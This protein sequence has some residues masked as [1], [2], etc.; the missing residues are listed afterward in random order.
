MHKLLAILVLSGLC[1]CT[2]PINPDEYKDAISGNALGAQ[3][4]YTVPLAYN[5]VVANLKSAAGRC[6]QYTTNGILTNHGWVALP[7]RVTGEVRV[8]KPGQAQLTVQSSGGT[9]LFDGSQK[10]K[11][12]WYPVH[13][14]RPGF[15]TRQDELKIWAVRQPVEPGED[16]GKRQ[17]SVSAPSCEA[18]PP[19][20]WAL[21]RLKCT[22]ADAARVSKPWP[23][24]SRGFGA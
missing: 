22:R 5:A 18:A 3:E 21:T 8:V 19:A 1:A 24:S 20:G 15:W 14:H 4:H 23:R 7:S 13:R 17:R 6:L 2:M 16:L 12:S 9:S 10:P 11:N